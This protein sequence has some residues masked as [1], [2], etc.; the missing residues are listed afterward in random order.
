MKK[1]ES[2]MSSPLSL[3]ERWAREAQMLDDAYKMESIRKMWSNPVECMY[4]RASLLVS[5]YDKMLPEV[6]AINTF[7][8]HSF[9]KIFHRLIRMQLPKVFFENKLYVSKA[10]GDDA[11]KI[12]FIHGYANTPQLE[13]QEWSAFCIDQYMKGY[14][15]GAE[16]ADQDKSY[17]L[18]DCNYNEI[19]EDLADGAVD[20]AG[21]ADEEATMKSRPEYIQC[22]A[23]TH[24]DYSGKSWCGI[25][26]RSVYFQ[27]LD[28][29]AHAIKAG[30]RVVPCPECLQAARQQLNLGVAP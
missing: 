25:S 24:G 15:K 14:A 22:I 4:Q 8:G 30:T 9:W 27:S 19:I 28:H 7:T 10:S 13:H 5:D 3:V 2:H 20:L 16:S 21:A 12:G 18:Y 1:A 17:G 29:A 23:H 26:G 6:K 11:H